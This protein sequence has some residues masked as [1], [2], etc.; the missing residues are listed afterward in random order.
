MCIICVQFQK[1][2]DFSDA[3]RM[4]MSARREPNSID[5]EHLKQIEIEINE[6]E[7]GE[8]KKN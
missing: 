4:I 5:V 7:A 3:R 6:A 8:Q 2:R 1:D